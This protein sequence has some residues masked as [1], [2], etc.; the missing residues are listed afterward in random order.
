MLRIADLSID[1]QVALRKS[2]SAPFA[3]NSFIVVAVRS[4]PSGLTPIFCAYS[5][6]VGA[7]VT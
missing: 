1:S 5:R 3:A 7:V 2:G 6:R 4:R